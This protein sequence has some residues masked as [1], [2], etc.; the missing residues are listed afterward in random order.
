MDKM[1]RGG[2]DEQG[3][4]LDIYTPPCVSQIASGKLL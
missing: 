4:W 1:G 2:G 3:E